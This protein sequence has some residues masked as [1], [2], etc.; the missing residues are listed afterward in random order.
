MNAVAAGIL[1]L[2]FLAQAQQ[3]IKDFCPDRI[4]NAWEYSWQIEPYKRESTGPK[5]GESLHVAITLDDY[6]MK[7]ND[8]LYLFNIWEK[9]I[10]TTVYKDSIAK[11][12]VEN[13]Y[14]ISVYFRFNVTAVVE[15]ALYSAILAEGRE[16]IS[17]LHPLYMY[18]SIPKDSLV[19]IKFGNDSLYRYS[20]KA[21][22][23]VQ[24]I[25]LVYDSTPSWGNGIEKLRLLSFNNTKYNSSVRR[26][27]D[28]AEKT[29]LRSLEQKA[30]VNTRIVFRGNRR[31]NGAFYSPIGRVISG[32]WAGSSLV[33][34]KNKGSMKLE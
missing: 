4:G 12:N 31:V 6:E 10:V 16:P 9:G 34:A 7:N 28:R 27:F 2:I 8:T 30:F 3:T 19:K 22:Q 32:Y 20:A 25:G 13:R 1:T 21:R 11:T 18:H 14:N 17:M 15:D 23:Y 24:N 33:F 26:A 5:I 29:T